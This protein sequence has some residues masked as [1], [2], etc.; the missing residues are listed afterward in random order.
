MPTAKP[1]K[2]HLFQYYK[3]MR[4][5]LF[6]T[7]LFVILALNCQ[8]SWYNP[9]SWFSSKV[10][11]G[12]GVI[13]TPGNPGK[14]YAPQ[15]PKDSS[16]QTLN[17]GKSVTVEAPA[18]SSIQVGKDGTVGVISTNI[19]QLKSMGELPIIKITVVGDTHN[20]QSLGAASLIVAAIDRSLSFAPLV[21]IGIALI[22]F[23]IFTMTT[24]GAALRIGNGKVTPSFLIFAGAG[25][26]VGAA[27]LDATPTWV[28]ALVFIAVLGYYALHY[29]FHINSAEQLIAKVQSLNATL[30][31]TAPAA[32][33]IAQ[34]T[35][36]VLTTS[37]PVVVPP[38][39]PTSPNTITN[40]P[41]NG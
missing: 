3:T 32:Q 9:I 18:G 36:P 17:Q 33:R 39:L 4:T 13:K 26:I 37:A 8:A 25:C 28:Y 22:L 21:Y 34:K 14:L 2:K 5:R 12:V 10:D 20:S 24:W 41:A 16:S 6:L 40:P 35:E 30:S 29:V 11:G 15:N 7:S 31:T 1:C 19:P 27:T 23:G 38:G